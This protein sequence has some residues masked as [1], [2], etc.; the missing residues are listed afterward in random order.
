[1]APPRMPQPL[2]GPLKRILGTRRQRPRSGDACMKREP[3]TDGIVLVRESVENPQGDITKLQPNLD[4]IEAVHSD[5]SKVHKAE[6]NVRENNILVQEQLHELESR[7]IEHQGI[8]PEAGR[9]QLDEKGA[10]RLHL[11]T[12]FPDMYFLQF[13]LLRLQAWQKLLE[14]FVAI[15]RLEHVFGGTLLCTKPRADYGSRCFVRSVFSVPANFTE[16]FGRLVK[17]PVIPVGFGT[18]ADH[19]FPSSC[20]NRSRHRLCGLIQEVTMCI[21]AS[22]LS[23]KARRECPRLLC[24]IT[25]F[26]EALLHSQL[27][28]YFISVNEKLCPN[29]AAH[30]RSVWAFTDMPLRRLAMKSLE[31]NRPSSSKCIWSCIRCQAFLAQRTGSPVFFLGRQQR[32]VGNT[33]LGDARS[34]AHLRVE[35]F[36]IPII[37]TERD[38]PLHRQKTEL[39]CTLH[40]FLSKGE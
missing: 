6:T 4:E 31:E 21:F 12:D 38:E 15:L 32:A 23:C 13:C 10:K 7:L 1:M 35:Q 39:D 14:F 9:Q 29:I 3:A 36:F 20:G 34:L 5:T 11:S 40:F 37:Q 8:R 18:A 33:R 16:E 19:R 25:S 27:M 24:M 26:G 28:T 2:L 22:P 17:L 30:A